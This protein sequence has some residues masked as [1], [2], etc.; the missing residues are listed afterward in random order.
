MTRTGQD[1]VRRRVV[2]EGRVQGVGFRQSCADVARAG[3][4]AGWVRNRRDG[5]V[6]AVFEGPAAAVDTMVDWCR[7]GP[8]AARVDRIEVRNEPPGALGGFR[9]AATG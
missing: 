9:V 4:V 2:V 3:R 8:P 7:S 5:R 1:V 6:E